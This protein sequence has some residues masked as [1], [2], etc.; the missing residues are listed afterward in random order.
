MNAKE[1][2]DR[3]RPIFSLEHLPPEDRHHVK[4]VE[5]VAKELGIEP[6]AFNLLQVADALE[7]NGIEGEVN[8][9]PK[10]LYSRRHHAEDIFTPSIYDARGDY[11]W[12]NVINADE[13]A[14]LGGDWVDNIAKLPPRGDTPV[15][16]EP[17]A[18]SEEK[19]QGA[20]AD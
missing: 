20:D 10:M 6:T 18:P 7:A 14:K 5:D 4:F 1:A 15:H 19:V 16:A 13:E 12:V 8:Q 2:A 9:Y 17:K 3:L 11:T